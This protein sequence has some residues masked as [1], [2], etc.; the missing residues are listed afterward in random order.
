MISLTKE[1]L[2]F[3]F[4]NVQFVFMRALVDTNNNILLIE[5]A[6][7]TYFGIKKIYALPLPYYID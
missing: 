7:L 6:D 4:S 5:N 3:D 1:F 2:F